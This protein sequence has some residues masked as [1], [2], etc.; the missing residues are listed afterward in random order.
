MRAMIYKCKI[1]K[2]RKLLENK[3]MYINGNLGMTLRNRKTLM[4]IK[5]RN[6]AR[7]IIK[8]IQKDGLI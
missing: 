2:L 7:D 6:R 3:E 8:I 1:W 5:K 4:W